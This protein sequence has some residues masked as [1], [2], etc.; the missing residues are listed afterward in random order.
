MEELAGTLA[1]LIDTL[2]GITVIILLFATGLA[3]TFKQATVLWRK[4]RKL[5]MSL[6]ATVVLTPIRVIAQ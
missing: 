1:A 5:V 2:I 6:L 3:M 4:P